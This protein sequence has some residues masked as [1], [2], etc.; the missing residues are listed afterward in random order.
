VT[1]PEI[2]RTIAQVAEVVL[3]RIDARP[4]GR[5]LLTVTEIPA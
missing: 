3:E 4:G 5:I 1:A 2:S